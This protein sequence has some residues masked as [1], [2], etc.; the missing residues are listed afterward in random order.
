M[1][2]NP[3]TSSEPQKSYKQL[4]EEISDDCDAAQP[5]GKQRGFKFLLKKTSNNTRNIVC[6]SNATASDQNESDRSMESTHV[7]LVYFAN[8]TNFDFDLNIGV[9][10]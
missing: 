2:K 1:L 6:A 10:F 5:R 4:S 3:F 9:E 8:S 7:N